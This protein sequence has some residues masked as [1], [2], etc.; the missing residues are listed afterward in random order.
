LLVLLLIL[1][2]LFGATRLPMIGRGMGEGIRNFKKGL[3]DPGSP[4]EPKS[5]DPRP[6]S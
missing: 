4:D 2:L 3:K 6:S 5:D 1:V